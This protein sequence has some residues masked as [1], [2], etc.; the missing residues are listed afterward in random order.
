MHRATG[1]CLKMGFR[2]VEQVAFLHFCSLFLVFPDDFSKLCSTFCI[3]LHLEK[4]SNTPTI[5]QKNDIFLQGTSNGARPEIINIL[6]SMYFTF[7]ASPQTS[8]SDVHHHFKP[9][10]APLQKSKPKL[11]GVVP[12]PPLIDLILKLRAL[13][14]I[15]ERNSIILLFIFN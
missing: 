1:I 7:S 13:Q 3:Q 2:L 12:D 8:M 11:F 4:S 15:S 5:W 6:R 10:L 14:L 9:R